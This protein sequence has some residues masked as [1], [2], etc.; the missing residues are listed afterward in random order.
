MRVDEDVVM[1]L[2][3]RGCMCAVMACALF[4]LALW[5]TL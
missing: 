1:K 4:A 2:Q 3:Y 5:G